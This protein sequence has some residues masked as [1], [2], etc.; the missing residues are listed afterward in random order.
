[1]RK[2]F[3]TTKEILYDYKGPTSGCHKSYKGTNVFGRH[4]SELLTDKTYTQPTS[5]KVAV[6]E[7][8][9]T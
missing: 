5:Y 9:S 3:N 7:M 1:M 4:P 2:Y 6:A 8:F